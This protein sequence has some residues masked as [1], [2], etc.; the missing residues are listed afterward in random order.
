MQTRTDRIKQAN[1]I[2]DLLEAIAQL[3][4]SNKGLNSGIGRYAMEIEEQALDY[5]RTQSDYVS[6]D[7]RYTIT[8]CLNRLSNMIQSRWEA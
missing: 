4:R 1:I 3:G 5:L 2:K 6:N 8:I 7:G